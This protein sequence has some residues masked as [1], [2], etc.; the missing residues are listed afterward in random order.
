MVPFTGYVIVTP[1][2]LDL[3]STCKN[4]KTGMDR[5]FWLENQ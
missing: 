1:N 3:K 2:T 5:Q 4:R